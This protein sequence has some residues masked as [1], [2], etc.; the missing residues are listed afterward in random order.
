MVL[1]REAKR[2]DSSVSKIVRQ[3]ITRHLG[4]ADA[5]QGPGFIAIGRS[6]RRRTARNAESILAREWCGARRR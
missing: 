1:S 5:D 2:L 6:G 3:A 4:V